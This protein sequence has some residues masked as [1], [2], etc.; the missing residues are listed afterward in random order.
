MLR[1][2]VVLVAFVVAA[3]ATPTDDCKACVADTTKE[4]CWDAQGGQT[5]QCGAVDGA[6]CWTKGVSNSKTYSQCQ[7][8]L[9]LTCAPPTCESCIADKT[10]MWC[11]GTPSAPCKAKDATCWAKGV[12]D[13]V[14]YSQCSSCS[15]TKCQGTSN[16]RGDIESA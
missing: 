1:V 6:R 16:L 15:D 11:W 4:W 2:A 9:D 3:T 8:C 13:D 5:G 7:D 14:T 10:K 12:S